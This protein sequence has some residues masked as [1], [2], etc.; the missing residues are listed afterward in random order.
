MAKKKRSRGQLFRDRAAKTQSRFRNAC[1]DDWEVVDL[2]SRAGMKPDWV[3]VSSDTMDLPILHEI[4]L[5][6]LMRV[7]VVD[8]DLEEGNGDE[9]N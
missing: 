8:C 6:E 7:P 2:R 4:R 5:R 3:E 1:D 9:T